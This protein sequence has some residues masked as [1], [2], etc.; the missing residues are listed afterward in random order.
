MPWW[1]SDRIGRW[2]RGR[3][4][5]RLS[6]TGGRLQATATGA[7]PAATV[8]VLDTGNATGEHQDAGWEPVER[9]GF[10]FWRRVADLPGEL[11]FGGGAA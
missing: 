6:L 8:L 11:A 3:R 4:Q 5:A 2:E 1:T 10:P 9:W 7:L